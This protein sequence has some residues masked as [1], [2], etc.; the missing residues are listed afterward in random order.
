MIKK[1]LAKD[2]LN[3]EYVKKVFWK[4][5]DKC[6]PDKYLNSKSLGGSSQT[7]VRQQFINDTKAIHKEFKPY[8]NFIEIQYEKFEEMGV[9]VPYWMKK[10]LA[11][12]EK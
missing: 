8:F 3:P 11:K 5:L 10:R 9:K 7:N 4:T 6:D 2:Q 12:Y 1:Y